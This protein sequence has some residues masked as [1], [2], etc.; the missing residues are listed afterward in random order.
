[1][2]C[3]WKANVSIYLTSPEA[4]LEL[5]D[6]DLPDMKMTHRVPKKKT[7]RTHFTCL[8]FMRNWFYTKRKTMEIH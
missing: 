4:T 2:V 7:H 8:V 5:F 1:M 3:H 6:P